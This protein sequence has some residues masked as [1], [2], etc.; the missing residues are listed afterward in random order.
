[1]ETELEENVVNAKGAQM[2]S[3]DKKSHRRKISRYCRFNVMDDFALLLFGRILRKNL[4]YSS[5]FVISAAR[6]IEMWGGRFIQE[7]I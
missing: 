6:I 2:G 5:I 4:L 7:R 1:L 3:T